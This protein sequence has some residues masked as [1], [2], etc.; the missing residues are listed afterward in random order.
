MRVK[1][2]HFLT[3]LIA[4]SM[5]H[6]TAVVAEWL[7]RWTRNPM[8]NAR[9]GSNPVYSDT[10]PSTCTNVPKFTRHATFERQLPFEIVYFQVII[11]LAACRNGSLS[12]VIVGCGGRVVKALDLKS[13][14]QCP[15]RF[16]SCP[17]RFLLFEITLFAWLVK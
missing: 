8:G 11:D 1:K 17:Q 16:E 15:R 14:G 6:Q 9:T 10:F 3:T 4:E 5:F 7:R 13:N 12:I 2:I